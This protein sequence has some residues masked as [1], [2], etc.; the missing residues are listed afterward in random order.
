MLQ[1]L[2]VGIGAALVIAKL[3]IMGW[4]AHGA[5]LKHAPGIAAWIPR[6]GG[7]ALG[8]AAGAGIVALWAVG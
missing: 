4:L 7:A 3:G 5:L 8:L 6:D 2:V 1:I